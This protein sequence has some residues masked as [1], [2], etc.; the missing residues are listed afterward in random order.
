MQMYSKYIHFLQNLMKV[1]CCSGYMAPEYAFDGK[2]SIKSDVFSMGVVIFE[3]VSGKKNRSFRF[4]SYYQNLLEQAWLLWKENRELELMDAC[5]KNSFVESQ[6]KRCIQVG[7]LCVQKLSEDRPIMSSVV[8]MLS[9]DDASLPRPK[10]PG[11]LS[12]SG[13]LLQT[14]ALGRE[15]ASSGTVTMTDVE[16]R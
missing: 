5:Y 2:F 9:S 14:N 10:K 7:L 1:S 3:I 11:F 15:E 8:L 16:A 13:N 12:E 6:V 4:P